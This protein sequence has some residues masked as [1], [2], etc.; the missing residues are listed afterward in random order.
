MYTT[1]KV[2]KRSSKHV[3]NFSTMKLESTECPKSH[4]Q[5]ARETDKSIM[6]LTKMTTGNIATLMTQI[7]TK[8]KQGFLIIRF[9]GSSANRSV[10]LVSFCYYRFSVVQLHTE[11]SNMANVFWKKNQSPELQD[12][13]WLNVKVQLWRHFAHIYPVYHK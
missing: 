12:H 11:K 13:Q 6:Q 7:K 3:H 4:P 2:D 1:Q 5:K 8:Q 10:D 9:N